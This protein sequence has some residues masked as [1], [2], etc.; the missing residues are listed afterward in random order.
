MGSRLVRWLAVNGWLAVYSLCTGA[1]A[2]IG[3]ILAAAFVP[4]PISPGWA[5]FATTA[6]LVALGIALAGPVLAWVE[7]RRPGR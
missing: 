4:S 7:L 6:I 5:W 2:T 1:V 3:G